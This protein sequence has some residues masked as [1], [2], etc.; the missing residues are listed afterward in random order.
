MWMGIVAER[1]GGG[2][3]MGIVAERAGEG[4]WMGIVA[5]R[6]GK[7]KKR[8]NLWTIPYMEK[9]HKRNGLAE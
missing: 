1:A 3:W 8:E 4:V 5:E 9:V 6:A 7:G 2:V